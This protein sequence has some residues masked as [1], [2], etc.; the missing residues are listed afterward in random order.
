DLAVANYGS[1]DPSSATAANSSISVLMGNGD[2]TFQTAVPYGA[3]LNPQVVVVSDFN[4]DGKLDLAVANLLSGNISVLWGNGNGTFQPA[5][6]FG[7]GSR[8]ITTGD[9][10][11]DGKPDLI[12]MNGS[13]VSM[14]LN[15]CVPI[16]FD[17]AIALSNSTV[18][19]SW[20]LPSAGFVLESTANLSPPSWQPA[21]EI[22]TTNNGR[23]EVSVLVDQQARYFRLRHP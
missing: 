23:L 7:G 15:I 17:L 10:N 4:G 6:D 13:V 1:F 14:L 21:A 19:V 20:P 2:G 11:G 16:D 18:V 5:A 12:G 9:F 8:S 3:E 22:A